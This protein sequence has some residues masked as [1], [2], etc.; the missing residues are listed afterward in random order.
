[1]TR[2]LLTD[3]AIFSVGHQ[4]EQL[5]LQCIETLEVGS[6]QSSNIK[7]G[8]MQPLQAHSKKFLLLQP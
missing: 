5:Y 4:T 3:T 1:M 6:Q 2:R 7:L 8:S